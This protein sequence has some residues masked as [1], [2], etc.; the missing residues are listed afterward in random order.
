[1]NYKLDNNRDYQLRNKT[2]KLVFEKIKK[3]NKT[4]ARQF[5]RKRGK[6]SP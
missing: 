3:I 1:M 6:V 5:K 4:L 2:P